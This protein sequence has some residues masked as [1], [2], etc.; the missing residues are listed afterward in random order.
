MALEN[1][2]SAERL[3]I[4]EKH[5]KVEH[6]QIMPA[7]H[8]NKALAGY[9][10]PALQCLDVTLL[11]ALDQAI[12]FYPPPG[13]AGLWLIDRNW[14]FSLPRYMGK[15]A[16]PKLWKRYKM[17]KKPGDP[18]GVLLDQYGHRVIARKVKEESLFDHFTPPHAFGR[19]D[20]KQPYRIIAA[21]GV[22]PFVIKNGCPVIDLLHLVASGDA[23]HCEA[24]N[25]R[26]EGRGGS[27]R[28][29]VGGSTMLQV[30]QWPAALCHTRVR[31]TSMS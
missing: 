3:D 11:N 14:I 15:K 30:Q 19:T 12:Q 18:Q 27:P 4:Y 17:A 16:N 5:F 21:C 29:A 28:L 13:A 2:I 9:M 1:F 10:L 23:A 6:H 20:T 8:W 25:S 26:S 22:K 31:L 7:Y 24:E